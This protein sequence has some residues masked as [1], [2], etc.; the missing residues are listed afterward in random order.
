MMINYFLK[1]LILLIVVEYNDL[2]RLETNNNEK[3]NEKITIK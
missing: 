1:D 3:N 2:L